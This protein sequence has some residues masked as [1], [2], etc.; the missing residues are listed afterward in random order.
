[1]WQRDINPEGFQWLVGDDAAGNTLAFVR[2]SESGEPLIAI[3]NFSPVPHENYR[4]PLPLSGK[5]QEVLNSDDQSYGGSGVTNSKI[6]TVSEECRGFP[7][8][9]VIR[10]PPLG[11]IWLAP[12]N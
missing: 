2:W 7:Y 4:I 10:V 8:S 12:D 11:T 3:T 1:M 6:D 5:W 9:A